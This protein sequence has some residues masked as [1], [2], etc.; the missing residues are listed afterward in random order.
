MKIKTYSQVTWLVNVLFLICLILLYTLL[1]SPLRCSSLIFSPLKCSSV[2]F[3]S[4]NISANLMIA[5]SIHCFVSIIA[6][7]Y[8]H[9]KQSNIN[10]II[11]VYNKNVP[12]IIFKLILYFSIQSLFMI[13]F[14]IAFFVCVNQY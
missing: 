2:Y 7:L 8:I 3:S 4:L 5:Y 12:I 10:Q 9:Y 11:F 13:S 14:F 6:S 1:F